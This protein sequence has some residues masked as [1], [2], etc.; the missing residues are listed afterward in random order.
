MLGSPLD[1]KCLAKA[2]IQHCSSCFLITATASRYILDDGLHDKEAILCSLSLQRKLQNSSVFVITD[3]IQDSN[4]QFLDFSD[5]DTEGELYQ[6]E[7]FACG[8]AFAASVFNS[9]TTTAYHR[10]GTIKLLSSLLSLK[11]GTQIS[12]SRILPMRLNYGSHYQFSDLYSQL[13]EQKLICIAVYRQYPIN[14]TKSFVIT[15]PAKDLVLNPSD[16]AIV[17]TCSV[18]IS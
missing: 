8:N 15:N 14:P 17:I 18:Q 10:P 13:L 3:L 11:Q 6:A 1:W 9:V 5:E 4:V 2:S 16:T 12:S 7:P